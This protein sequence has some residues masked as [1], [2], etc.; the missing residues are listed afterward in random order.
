MDELTC[1]ERVSTALSNRRDGFNN[2]A[3]LHR[4]LR[5]TGTFRASMHNTGRNQ[6]ELTPETE[7]E[8]LRHVEDTPSTSTRLIA[9]ILDVR[10]S[11]V[12]NVLHDQQLHPF[13]IQRV[14]TLARKIFP[15]A[16]SS[17]NGFSNRLSC[18]PY[19]WPRSC[20][21]TRLC[22]LVKVVVISTIRM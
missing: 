3:R 20:T 18:I 5:V 15:K 4:L 17:H 22:L 12:W 9:H 7:D 6:T 2:F 19:F 16:C 11:L 10:H 14:A 21:P 8:I 1:S 13:H